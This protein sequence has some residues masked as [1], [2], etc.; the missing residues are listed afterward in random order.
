MARILLGSIITSIAGSIG[1]TTFRRSANGLVMQN[2][3]QVQKRSAR[4]SNS[5]ISQIAS[6][7]KLWNSFDNATVTA[8]NNAALLYEFKNK[9]GQPVYYSGRQ[10]FVKCN[11]TTMLFGRYNDK[12]DGVHN[13]LESVYIKNADFNIS[14]NKFDITLNQPLVKCKLFIQ[15]EILRT[16]NTIFQ[17]TSNKVIFIA[18]V[19]NGDTFRIQDQVN[20]YLGAVGRDQI[21][22]ITNQV[23]NDWGFKQLPV[24][25]D[26]ITRS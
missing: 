3:Q 17:Q 9:F 13:T 22:R 10:L 6:I 12:P 26:I 20:D 14:T 18:T 21:I 24:F 2:K 1:G 15:V 4:S 19:N 16:A 5:R 8:W 23:V 7:I 11:T 25:I